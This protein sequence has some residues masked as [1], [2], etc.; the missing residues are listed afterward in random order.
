MEG[1]LTREMLD[2]QLQICTSILEKVKDTGN[3]DT[4]ELNG[5]SVRK[6][7][8]S[9]SS[10]LSITNSP[11]DDKGNIEDGPEIKIEYTD[12]GISKIS[13]IV[14][15][16][17]LG[18]R[19][20]ESDS[21]T[22]VEISNDNGEPKI[23][24]IGIK[25]NAKG[26]HGWE[27]VNNTREINSSRLSDYINSGITSVGYAM[28]CY[29]YNQAKLYRE[30][31][32]PV[33]E[34][35]E[36]C[37]IQDYQ[38][39][40][41]PLL[42]DTT[43]RYLQGA[44]DGIRC[45]VDNLQELLFQLGMIEP[46][47]YR[48][49][50]E[51]YNDIARIVVRDCLMSDGLSKISP[52]QELSAVPERKRCSRAERTQDG[53]QSDETMYGRGDKFSREVEWHGFKV[54][55]TPNNMILERQNAKSYGIQLIFPE[56]NSELDEGCYISVGAGLN[57]GIPTVKAHHIKVGSDLED[58]TCNY[59]GNDETIKKTFAEMGITDDV[60]EVLE[61]R[62]EDI[63]SGKSVLTGEDLV[64]IDILQFG[65]DGL[66]ILNEF[67]IGRDATINVAARSHAIQEAAIATGVSTEDT[68]EFIEHLV[69]KE[70]RDP[71]GDNKILG[72]E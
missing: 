19:L 32:H 63:R 58:S 43:Y 39:R 50:G 57:L 30:C 53:K 7:D 54:K 33:D 65:L 49:I 17:K 62:I 4:V 10:I 24:T 20:Y 28:S 55:I 46:P 14:H 61:K 60:T 41:K 18:K 59:I 72:E 45:Q 56:W 16:W 5:C 42:I 1:N 26:F 2:R 66:R 44:R 13:Y 68:R 15:H 25:L 67:T 38:L 64:E 6:I 22:L 29:F 27:L 37:S 69:G 21:A 12:S 40:A 11:R 34:G 48:N 31:M 23:S 47:K 8:E 9:G 52:P 36:D 3:G 71:K 70:A 51:K 35:I